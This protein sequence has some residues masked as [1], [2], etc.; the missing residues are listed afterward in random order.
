MNVESR[1]RRMLEELADG[2]P[3]VPTERLMTRARRRRRMH[4]VV[5]AAVPICVVLAVGGAI[6]AGMTVFSPGPN[7]GGAG[8]GR[9]ASAAPG[10]CGG[11]LP[12]APVATGPLRIGV[13]LT[14]AGARLTGT[15]TVTNGGAD[16]VSGFTATV[17]D[18]F[19]LSRGRIV[20]TPAP[21]RDNAVALDLAPGASKTFPVDVGPADCAQPG[22]RLAPGDYQLV[23]RLSVFTGSSRAE[24]LLQ[25]APVTFRLV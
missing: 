19:V 24:T 20:T 23:A 10:E 14:V 4:R 6:L 8:G 1:V 25:T 18:Y 21:H 12:A 3:E 9:E 16:P 13:D 2:A 15:T 22:A 17:P 7:P 11:P 5:L